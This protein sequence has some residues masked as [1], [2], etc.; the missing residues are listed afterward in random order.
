MIYL[1]NM[2]FITLLDASESTKYSIIA[3]ANSRDVPGPWL[4]IKFPSTTTL[5]STKLPS[6]SDKAG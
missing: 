2:A 5:S 3:P 1:T 4:V 6:L